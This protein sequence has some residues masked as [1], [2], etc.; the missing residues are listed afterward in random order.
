MNELLSTINNLKHST[1]QTKIQQRIKE[2]KTIDTHSAEELFKE[3]CFCILT[4]NFNAERSIHIHA[5]LSKCFCSDTKETLAKKLKEQGYRFPNTRAAFIVE[6]ASKKDLLPTMIQTLQHEERRA[7]L[8]D[9]IKG[10]GY[11]E[12]S[13][14]LRNIGYDDYAIID[15]HILDFL[16]RHHLITQP[17]TLTK[18]K[19]IEIEGYLQKIARNTQL[20]LAELDLYLWYLATGKILK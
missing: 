13:H 2:F 6:S 17:K 11:K 19:Y 5:H 9:N 16:E 8:A 4:A 20:T 10:L 3:L 18:R 7:W 1:I 15:S 14:F 12:A